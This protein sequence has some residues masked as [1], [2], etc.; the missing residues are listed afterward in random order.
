MIKIPQVVVAVCMIKRK[1]VL[2][3]QLSKTLYHVVMLRDAAY[4]WQLN[5]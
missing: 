4:G 5:I 2:C 1:A 3:Y